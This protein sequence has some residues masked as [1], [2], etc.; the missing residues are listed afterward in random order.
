ME[1]R[2]VEITSRLIETKT[3]NVQSSANILI[4]RKELN[5]EDL[6]SFNKTIDEFNSAAAAEEQ[7]NVFDSF[8]GEILETI[9]P[10]VKV[11]IQPFN[12]RK[13]DLPEKITTGFN[14]RPVDSLLKKSNFKINIIERAKLEDIWKEAEEFGNADFDKLVK[15]ADAEILIIGD[16]RLRKGGVEISYRGYDPVSYTHLTLPTKRIV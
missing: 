10:N 8:A 3:N 16:L 5:P 2:G 7:S 12:S 9:D 11:A 15:E 1:R 6:K 14:N 4:D 13:V